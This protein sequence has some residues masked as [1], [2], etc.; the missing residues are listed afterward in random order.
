MAARPPGFEDLAVAFR[1]GNF[2]PLYFFYGDEGFLMD[3]LQALLLEHALAPHERD[4][5]LDLFHGPDADVRSVL[6]ACAAFPMMAA[7][8]VVVVRGFER[9]QDNRRFVTYAEAPNP[10]AVVLLLC[11]GKPNLAAHP[12]RAL[13]QHA[14]AVEFKPLYDRQMP[15]WIAE[16]A[17]GMG[18]KVEAAAA[19]MLAQSVGSDLR[20]AAVEL[21][22]LQAYAGRRT[23][24]TEADVLEAG[25][26]LREYN[27]F[28]LQ[29]ALGEGDRLRATGIVE[30]LLAQASNRSG[31]ALRV[32]A[33]LTRYLQQLRRLSAIQSRR[34]P[35]AEQARHIGVPPFFLKEYQSALRRLGPGAVRRGLEA[36]LAA[37]FELK[38]GSARDPRLVLLLVLRRIV[39]AAP[40]ASTWA[41]TDVEYPAIPAGMT[42]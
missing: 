37:D 24:L 4:F 2:Q 1:H 9:L 19:Q 25:G 28:E 3:E 12:Y 7:R 41:G 18:L 27:V 13:K 22:K 21:E 36:L 16:R 29:K 17:R 33:M 38:G 26:H 6:G 40:A 35:D 31:E 10:A 15:G 20:A 34:L 23:I 11:A 5:N 39:P 42:G 8:R 30:R 14:A 32:V